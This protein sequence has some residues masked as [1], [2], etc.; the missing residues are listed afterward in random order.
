MLAIQFESKASTLRNLPLKQGLM[1]LFALAA[2]M[3]VLPDDRVTALDPASIR[4]LVD[5][6]QEARLLRSAALDLAP[7]LHE[8]PDELDAATADAMV[9]RLAR[10]VDTL[11]ES[12]SPA[13]EWPVMREIFGDPLLGQLTGVAEVSLRRYAAGSRETPQAVAERL[14]WLAL[15]VCDLA[16]GYNAYGIRR[17]FER[18][19]AQLGGLSPRAL[20]G[21]NWSSDDAAAA[22]VRALAAAL[23]GAQPLAA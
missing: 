9:A 7:L 17:W 3:G 19:R 10:L 20:L 8:T 18:P 21:A 13:T 15:V 6:L 23:S 2:A 22:R 4:R 1:A 14:H 11:A 16:G 12:P 5:G